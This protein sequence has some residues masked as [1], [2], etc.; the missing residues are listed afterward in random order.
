S[1]GGKH[2]FCVVILPGEYNIRAGDIMKIFFPGQPSI[3]RIVRAY[4]ARIGGCSLPKINIA[5]L[6]DQRIGM[7]ISHAGQVRQQGSDL[8]VHGYTQYPAARGFAAFR[9]VEPPV[10]IYN[11]CPGAVFAATCNN[12]GAATRLQP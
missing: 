10:M 8:P 4:Y 9:Y 2:I 3:L 12:S 11:A 7:M 1:S 6:Y 5:V